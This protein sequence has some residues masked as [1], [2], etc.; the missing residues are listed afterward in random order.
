MGVGLKKPTSTF[1]QTI[2]LKIRTTM[3]KFLFSL[4]VLLFAFSGLQ[5]QKYFTREGKVSFHSDAPMEKI[6]AHNNSATGIVD[7]ETAR[8][9]FAVLIK[10]FQFE[11]ALMQE[12]FN[13][14]Y[15][16]SGKFPK[17]TFKGEIVNKSE[18]NFVKAGT[19]KVKVKGEMTLHGVT[20]PM[21]AN[22]T[23]T[24][25]EGMVSLA[26]EFEIMVADYNIQIPAVVKDNIAKVVKVTLAMDCAPF[27][28]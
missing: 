15:M 4:T 26:S 22:G 11:K 3:K 19:Y 14:N 7:F 23:L 16:E 13:E 6:E 27:N 25:K 10:A 24:I 20:K 28:R 1:T 5:A 12:H 2:F 18:V 8:M 17:A 9:E 21:E